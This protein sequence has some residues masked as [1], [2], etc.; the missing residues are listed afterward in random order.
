MTDLSPA[1]A[2]LG[3]STDTA[4]PQVTTPTETP[5]AGQTPQADRPA[6]EPQAETPAGETEQKTSAVGPD[7]QPLDETK[8]WKEKRQERNRQRWQE[9]KQAR[10]VIPQRLAVLERQLERLTKAPTPDFSRIEDPHEAIAERAAWKNRQLATEDARAQLDEERQSAAREQ[11]IRLGQA[12][13]EVVEDARA[14]LPDFDQV[15]N[16]KTYIHPRMA[17]RLLASESAAEIAYYLGKNPRE[18][19]ALFDKFN[20]DPAEAYEAFGELRTKVAAPAPR[21]VSNAPKPAPLLNG[22][23][24]PKGFDIATA[25]VEET[26]AHLKKM[27]VIR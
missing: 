6:G 3:G 20:S 26:K 12:W 19:K 24:N 15:V 2:D 4:A 13:Q 11:E 18:A 23:A 9:Y 21:Q 8:T 5:I 14:R 27:G 1:P 22:G 16:E 17:P 10:E 7:G 25:S